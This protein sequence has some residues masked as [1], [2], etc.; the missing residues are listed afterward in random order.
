MC[1]IQRRF[2]PLPYF[3]MCNIYMHTFRNYLLNR[4]CK[5]YIYL[6]LSLQLFVLNLK[7]TLPIDI[8]YR[9]QVLD[10]EVLFIAGPG[11]FVW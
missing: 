3:L 9:D 8:P 7:K 2:V 4:F 11:I 10:G 1:L 6:K 5:L